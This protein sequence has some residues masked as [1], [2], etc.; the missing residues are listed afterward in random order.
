M[1]EKKETRSF[2]IR[3][4][5]DLFDEVAEFAVEGERTVNQQMIYFIKKGLTAERTD[6][7]LIA[8]KREDTLYQPEDQKQT[9]A[10]AG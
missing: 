5:M 2:S 6:L 1:K 7:E 8:R 9:A 3:I 10:D 4:A